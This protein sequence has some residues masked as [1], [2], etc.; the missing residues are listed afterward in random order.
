MGGVLWG[1]LLWTRPDGAAYIAIAGLVTLLFAAREQ[2]AEFFALIK[3]GLVCTAVYLPWFAWSWWYYGSPIP[4]S[5]TA[6]AG[7]ARV[8]NKDFLSLMSYYSSKVFEAIC[9][10]SA[11]IYTLSDGWPDWVKWNSILIGCI[12]CSYFVWARSDR[13]GRIASVMAILV[14]G[15]LGW[16]GAIRII[17]PWYYPPLTLL[18]T[19]AFASAVVHF[20]HRFL[21]KACV[22]TSCIG[23]WWLGSFVHGRFA[24]FSN[25]NVN[26]ATRG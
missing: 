23:S 13:F 6:K 18:A 24:W 17:F 10:T 5:I 9:G 16:I 4:H 22:S 7:S 20:A 25:S 1:F 15:F 19:V 8:F 3:A 14:A 21:P 2:V 11:P 26:P 12:A